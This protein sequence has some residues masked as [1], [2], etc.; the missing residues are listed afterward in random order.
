MSTKLI[1]SNLSNG[2]SAPPPVKW[3]PEPYMMKACSW[4]LKHYCAGLF[5]DPGLGKTSINLAAIKTL[6]RTGEM[7]KKQGMLVIA[8]LRPVYNVWDGSNPEAEPRKWLDFNELR[9]VVL[10]GKEKDSRVSQPADVYII[11]PDGLDWLFSGVSPSRYWPFHGLSVDESTDFKHSGT[12]RFDLLKPRLPAFKRRWINT[13][14]PA[15]NGLLDLFGQIYI[16]D[17]GN[18]LGQYITHY[19][20]QFFVPGGF[21]YGGWGTCSLQEGAEKRIYK[22]IEPLILRMSAKDYMKLPRL[23]GAIGHEGTKPHLV[24]TKLPAKARK[25]YD[26]L[27]ELFFAELEDGSITA[28]NAGVKTI[29][30]RQVTNGGIYLDKGGEEAGVTSKR[31]WSL[32]HEVKT[33]AAVEMLEEISGRPA[34]IAIEFHHDLERLRQNKWLRNLPAIGEGS[35]KDDVLLARALNHGDIRCLAVNPAS[36]SRG[37]NMQA[38]AD[39]LIWHSMTYNWEHYWQ[40]VLRFWRKGRTRPFFVHHLIAENTVD[41]AMVYALNRKVKTQSGL[42]DALRAYSFRRPR[43]ALRD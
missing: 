29:K 31:R 2:F 38:G 41:L 43:P 36:F 10:H 15:P 19:K 14:T 3:I 18:A 22:R 33:D 40:L 27:E 17:L 37:S 9:T 11:N 34:V 23:I 39:H 30:L 6:R 25:V 32:I 7:P 35:I 26:N 8:P 13:G 16:L 1:A 12:V 20:R 5:L 21:G 42:L 28:S 4:L 24:K